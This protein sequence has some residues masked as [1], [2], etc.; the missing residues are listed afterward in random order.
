MSRSILGLDVGGANLKAA[1]ADG[2]AL[3]RPFALWKQAA[4][5][6]AALAELVKA[7]PRAHLLV[8]TMTGELCDC[9]A[10]KRE[11]V[12]AILDAV[13]QAAAGTPVRVWNIDG[14]FV[15]PPTARHAPLNVAAANWLAL[16]TYA[17]SLAP[18]GPAVLID[19]GTTTTD[20]VPLLDG[21]PV[22]RGRTDSERL[23]ASELVYLGWR[24]TPVCA[25]LGLEVAAEYFATAHDAYLVLGDV[26][27]DGHDCDTADSR[28]ATRAHAE[29]RLARMLC[30][31]MDTTTPEQRRSL[32]RKV[33]AVLVARLASACDNVIRQQ[34]GQEPQ[35]FI[36]SGSGEFL[37]RRMLKSRGHAQSGNVVSLAEKLGSKISTAA[38]AY[39][40]TQ[41]AGKEPGTK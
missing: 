29:A 37:A 12:A 30:G 13:E 26:E 34:P 1:H 22:P 18:S 41:I 10:T 17:G 8:V 24:R 25:I 7:M 20:I 31:D 16:A 27:E 35:S 14:C 15:D 33:D 38:C 3:S 9:Y 4:E 32:A 39:A 40:L 11:G 6:P 36:I 28:P 2:T 23:Q 19:I 5:L 21:L